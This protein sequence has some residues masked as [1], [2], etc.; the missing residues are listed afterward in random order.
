MKLS[1]TIAPIAPFTLVSYGLPVTAR[2]VTE[3]KVTVY[4]V[5]T[6]DNASCIEAP[7]LEG[8]AAKYRALVLR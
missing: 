3:G 6:P 5:A 8:L 7:T 4:T 1:M 2:K